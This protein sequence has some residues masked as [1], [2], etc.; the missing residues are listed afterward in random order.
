MGTRA[1][2]SCTQYEDLVDGHCLIA[3]IQHHLNMLDADD[4]VWDEVRVR[5]SLLQGSV[6]ETKT[7]VEF[8]EMF[9][10]HVCGRRQGCSLLRNRYHAQAP[11]AYLHRVCP[12][13]MGSI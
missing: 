9:D 2:L 3:P 5:P 6:Y 7:V 4:D 8:H 10:A 13:T 1:Y 12:V 11:E